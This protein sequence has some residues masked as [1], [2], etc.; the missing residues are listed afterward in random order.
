MSDDHVILPDEDPTPDDHSSVTPGDHQ[1][2]GEQ[3]PIPPGLV[4][5]ECGTHI[6][7]NQQYCLACGAPTP[8]AVPLRARRSAPAL[9]AASLLALGVGG[10]SIIYAA[11]N[12]D[13]NTTAGVSVPTVNTVPTIPT[14]PTGTNPFPTGSTFSTVPTFS[15]LTTGATITQNNTFTTTYTVTVTRTTGTSTTS[16]TDY[17][18]DDDWPY[19]NEVRWTI[20]MR[21]Y[22]DLIDAQNYCA[23]LKTNNF[24]CGI[25]NSDFY[26][27]LNP[28][29][30]V[31]FHKGYTTQASANTALAGIK[32]TYPSAYVRKIEI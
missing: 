13:T 12:E 10:A 25:L 14:F 30:F 20:V 4:C 23:T 3:H 9:I 1:A 29:Y 27:S 5:S 7:P 11:T 16:T 22:E 6:E 24:T 17:N 15:T 26:S 32:S 28:G 19:E 2:A 31:V 18:E 21:S 8:F